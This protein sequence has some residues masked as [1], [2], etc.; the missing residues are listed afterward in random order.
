MIDPYTRRQQNVSVIL[1]RK[2]ALVQFLNEI[3]LFKFA[4]SV[5]WAATMFTVKFYIKTTFGAVQMCSV[6]RR[7]LKAENEANEN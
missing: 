1:T 4:L 5:K 3:E 6:I 7:I 2:T